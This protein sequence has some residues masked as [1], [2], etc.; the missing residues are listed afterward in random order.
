MAHHHAARASLIEDAVTHLD[1]ALQNLEDL[2]EA[3]Q[4]S[5]DPMRGRAR[6]VI[7]TAKRRIGQ[8]ANDLEDVR[9]EMF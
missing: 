9:G 8:A 2:I 4:H 6:A 7:T 3:L 5:H 1:H